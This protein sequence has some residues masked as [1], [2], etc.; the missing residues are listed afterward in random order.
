MIYS[1]HKGIE[2]DFVIPELKKAF[3]ANEQI[4]SSFSQVHYSA[5]QYFSVTNA[6]QMSIPLQN[7][8]VTITRQEANLSAEEF[9]DILAGQIIEGSYEKNLGDL[10]FGSNISIKQI[11]DKVLYY[12]KLCFILAIASMLVIIILLSGRFVLLG[13][14]LIF[15]SLFFYPL[16]F[17]IDKSTE[18]LTQTLPSQGIDMPGLVMAVFN[19][20]FISAKSL[21]LY[22]FIAGIVWLLLGILLKFLGVGLWFQSF[23]EK[24]DKKK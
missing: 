21:F 13:I 22:V 24:K 8:M 10:G 23:F 3:L 9:R 7:N 18:S 1:F 14:D 16:K 20:A 15:V 19:Q 5:K 12:S 11:D 17:I 6:T 2:K 4:A